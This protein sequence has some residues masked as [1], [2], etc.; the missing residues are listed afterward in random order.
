MAPFP[1][2]SPAGSA[3]ESRIQFDG[4]IKRS[5]GHLEIRRIHLASV[6]FSAPTYKL[7]AYQRLPG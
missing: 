3:W 4:K 1:L 6:R 7:M 2:G 5:R